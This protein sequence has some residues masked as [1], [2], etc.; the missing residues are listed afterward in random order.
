MVDGDFRADLGLVASIWIPG[1]SGPDTSR[2]QCG[3]SGVA[4]VFG[5]RIELVRYDGLIPIGVCD[6]DRFLRYELKNAIR[7][8]FLLGNWIG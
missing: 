6:S 8:N 5:V 7:S 4:L 2:A 3:S 1:Y